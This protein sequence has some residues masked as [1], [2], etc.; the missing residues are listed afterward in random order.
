MLNEERTDKSRVNWFKLLLIVVLVLLVLTLL[1]KVGLIRWEGDS[2]KNSMEEEVVQQVQVAPNSKNSVTISKDEWKALQREVRQLRKEVDQLKSNAAKASSA[3][4]STAKV[5]SVGTEDSGDVIDKSKIYAAQEDEAKAEATKRR[6]HLTTNSQSDNSSL[7][8][9]NDITLVNYSHDWVESNATV[10][11]KNNLAR[12]ITSISGRMIYYDMRDNMLDYQDFT[13]RITIDPGMVKSIELKGY[14]YRDNYA[15]YKNKP[16]PGE[17]NR[18][19][20]VQFELK[21]YNTK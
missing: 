8:S 5:V 20:K 3:K 13:K 11:F 12:T 14:G 10:A 16:V 4:A 17:E 21:S 19:Y 1:W 9:P 15:Y 7:V 2:V 18:I 6:T